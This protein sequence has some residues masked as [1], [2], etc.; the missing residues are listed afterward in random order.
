MKKFFII[1]LSLLCACC[2]A[3]AAGCK[4]DEHTHSWEAHLDAN[5]EE[6]LDEDGNVEYICSGCGEKHEHTFSEDEYSYNSDSHWL[7]CTCESGIHDGYT[8]K[9]NV[10][11]H[12]FGDDNV[13]S[14]CS[15]KKINS[16]NLYFS[17]YAY[18]ESGN[19]IT[20]E[21]NSYIEVGVFYGDTVS[22]SGE[23]LDTGV[24]NPNYVEEGDTITFSVTKSVYCEYSPSSDT[25]PR[26]YANNTAITHEQI[27]GQDVYTLDISSS[28]EINKS[29]DII[30][31]VGN[32]QTKAS[33]ISGSGTDDDPYTIYEPV[34]WLYFSQYINSDFYNS[35]MEYNAASW[36][37]G[38]DLDFCG[39]QIYMIGDGYSSTNAIFCGHFDGNGYTL[40]NFTISNDVSQT[41][42]YSSYGGVFGV[43]SA[44]TGSGVAALVE[45]LNVQNAT[46]EINTAYTDGTTSIGI[47]AG[48]AIGFNFSNCSAKDVEVNFTSN[49]GYYGYM[50]GIVGFLASYVDEDN[51]I[52]Y[53]S[54]IQYCSAKDVT[55]NSNGSI[56]ASGGIVGYVMPYSESAPIF[57]LNSYFNGTLT[58]GMRTGGIAGEK[59]A[60]TS[61]QNCYAYGTITANS[62]MGESN[63]TYTDGSVYDLRYVYAGGIIGYAENYTYIGSCFFIGQTIANSTSMGTDYRLTD[64]IC[65]GKSKQGYDN[66][67]A[68]AVMEEN[69]YKEWTSVSEIDNS[70]LGWNTVDWAFSEGSLPEINPEEGD[71]EI[72]VTINVDGTEYTKVTLSMYYSTSYWYLMNDF[73]E[74]GIPMYIRNS[75]DTN[76]LTYGYY[77]DSDCT[78][79]IPSCYVPV[80]NITYYAKYADLSEI[81]E[82]DYYTSGNGKQVTIRLY[83]NGMYSYEEGVVYVTGSYTYDG[84]TITFND[85][86]FSRLSSLAASSGT[87]NALYYDFFAYI[88]ED[89]NLCIFDC[90]AIVSVSDSNY[91]ALARFFTKDSPLMALSEEN[92]VL[93]GSYY[94]ADE[95]ITFNKDLTGTIITQGYSYDVIYY[96]ETNDGEKTI[97]V[98]YLNNTYTATLT[99]ESGKTTLT[100]TATEGGNTKNFTAYDEFMGTWESEGLIPEIYTFDGKG[101]FTYSYAGATQTGTYSFTQDNENRITFTLSGD[102]TVTVGFNEDGTIV[103]DKTEGEVDFYKVN[104]YAGKWYTSYNVTNYTLDLYGINKA[105]WGL[106]TYDGT[107]LR[108]TATSSTALE[109]YY[110]DQLYAY[111]TYDATNMTLT[112]QMYDIS[113]GELDIIHVFYLYDLF[114]GTWYSQIDGI[115]TLKFNGF[116]LYSVSASESGTRAMSGEVT[117]T[118]TDGSSTTTTYTVN[119]TTGEASFTYTDVT[120]TL[121]ADAYSGIITALY[122]S[123]SSTLAKQDIVIDIVFEALDGTT[124][125]FDGKSNT[126]EG[127][128]ATI[129]TASESSTC[130]YTVSYDDEGYI[131]ITLES[132]GTIK[133]GESGYEIVTSDQSAGTPLYIKNAYTGTWNIKG[134]YSSLVIGKMTEPS[135]NGSNVTLSGTLGTQD[136]TLTYDGTYMTF[137]YYAN[138]YYVLVGNNAL[139]ISSTSEINDGVIAVSPDI[140]WGTWKDTSGNEITFSGTYL[141]GYVNSPIVKVT[142]GGNSYDGTYRISG[143][144]ITITYSGGTLTLTFE[145]GDEGDTLKSSDETLTFTK[146]TETEKTG[147]DDKT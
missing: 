140:V 115:E 68:P 34:D 93:S 96:V 79:A 25:Y 58:G 60:Y 90:D 13:C 129:T 11:E 123:T 18:D 81:V 85:A 72:T 74:S 49:T 76:K 73:G 86:P 54:T 78:K 35:Y 40:K 16:Y 124:Y 146:D 6:I 53:Y 37:L 12:N 77:F 122:S 2:L 59:V 110:D 120:Y 145:S 17:Y 112:G 39:E 147:T 83:A 82:K 41:S 135:V 67:Y 65:A 22:S 36:A 108:Y 111:L 128:T 101:G 64:K 103:I 89:G 109:M 4:K 19:I 114:A 94:S 99:T 43:C 45:N 33:T 14:V 38:A 57:I 118:P 5:G 10:E 95:E 66:F 29:G 1:F 27:D 44:A 92:V 62:S 31:W 70:S 55:L 130:K 28:L 80:S 26:A 121:T 42:E 133:K 88:D 105:G 8:P 141:S 20:D 125:S 50:G 61:V 106:A 75:D 24:D 30:I 126:S 131:V 3:C 84:E 102:I 100:L 51:Q 142:L 9:K 46:Y 139:Y 56:Y 15:Y 134:T 113:T 47:I 91:D 132:S 143:S 144:T 71:L 137:T 116:G 69:N 107:D 48:Y 32:V 52:A 119:S 138:T 87:Q 136:I 21:G 97:Y 7:T 127:G 104:S 117:I 63:T 98:E 23:T